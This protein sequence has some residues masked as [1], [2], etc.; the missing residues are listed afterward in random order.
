MQDPTTL[1]D[2]Q[3][4]AEVS[5]WEG[6]PYWLRLLVGVIL[7]GL[8]ASIAASQLRAAIPPSEDPKAKKL[9]YLYAPSFGLVF[10]LVAYPALPSFEWQMRLLIGLCAPFLWA[11]FYAIVKARYEK[12]L[13]ITLPDANQLTGASAPSKSLPPT[14][15]SSS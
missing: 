11:P 15:G 4:L 6:L 5:A 12:Q 10:G 2:V 13:G 9:H 14:G 7:I 1:P 3:S 8:G